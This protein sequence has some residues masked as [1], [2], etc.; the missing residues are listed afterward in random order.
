M[1]RKTFLSV[2]GALGLVIGCVALFAPAVILAGKGVD[3][4]PAPLVWVREVGVLI[5][6]QSV[7]VLLV[8]REPD[9]VALRAVL[10]GNA[11]VHAGLFPVEIAAFRTGVIARIDGILPNSVLHLVCAVG[12]VVLATRVVPPRVAA[13]G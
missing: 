9:T 1:N 13:S 4:S 7:V 12:F 10:W 3:P 11:L 5:V 2:V 6:A 8:R